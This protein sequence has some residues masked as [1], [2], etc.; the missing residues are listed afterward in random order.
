MTA[1][2]DPIGPTIPATA[3]LRMALGEL[4]ESGQSALNVVDSIGVI[5]GQ[6]GLDQVLAA[7]RPLS[8]VP[9]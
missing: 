4:M 5:V 8:E 1:S 3:N 2:L 6:I 7:S 9:P